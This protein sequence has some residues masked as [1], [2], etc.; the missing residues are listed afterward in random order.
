V[1]GDTLYAQQGLCRQIV[2]RGGEYFFTLKGNQPTLLEDTVTIFADSP[3]PLVYFEE[4]DRRGNRREVRRLWASSELAEYSGWPYL[5]QVCRIQ[6]ETQVKGQIK[7]EEAYA[8][9]S[10]WPHEAGAG[11]LLSMNRGHWR[12][13]NCLHYVRDV[14]Y[15]EDKSQVRTGNAPRVMAA[16]RNTAIGVMRL[17]GTTNIASALRRNAA[18]P[19]EALRLLGI[20]ATST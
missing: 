15:G 10:L 16:L 6:R 4:R 3:G 7:T 17:S 2:E 5:G 11:R 19:R 20:D 9:T 12:I 13:E 14:T 18:R 1:T 8:I